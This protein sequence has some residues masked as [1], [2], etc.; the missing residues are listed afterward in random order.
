MRSED[1]G[2]LSTREQDKILRRNRRNLAIGKGVVIMAY[3]LRALSLVVSV[4]F[5]AL[6]IVL[7]A[8]ALNSRSRRRR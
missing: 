5:W 2:M 4:V 7:M 8:S 1:V 6:T 3:G